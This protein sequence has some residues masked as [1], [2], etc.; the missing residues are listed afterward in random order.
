MRLTDT[1]ESFIL[2]MLDDESRQVELQ[3][4]ELA[5]HF[6]CAPSQIN[7]VLATRF[8]PERGYVIESKRGGGGY[9]RVTR[10]HMEGAS[11]I[12]HLLTDGIGDALSQDEARQITQNLIGQGIIGEKQQR[13]MLAAMSDSAY[14]PFSGKSTLRVGVMKSMLLRILQDL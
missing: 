12:T 11:Y 4:G 7:Y 9:I 13:L 1:I 6:G 8:T 5:R 2:S 10:V 14:T 3:R